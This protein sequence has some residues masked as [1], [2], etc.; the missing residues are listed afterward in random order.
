MKVI[1]LFLEPIMILFLLSAML[2]LQE[3][4]WRYLLLLA[5]SSDDSCFYGS[6]FGF[7]QF[8]LSGVI[9]VFQAL[10][11]YLDFG[12]SAKPTTLQSSTS[13]IQ[14]SS[15]L[16]RRSS[17]LAGAIVVTSIGVLV[18]LKRSKWCVL[19]FKRGRSNSH[20]AWI[21]ELFR[22]LNN[23][24]RQRKYWRYW[25]RRASLILI[26]MFGISIYPNEM[27]QSYQLRW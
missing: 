6:S 4:R 16:S 20:S 5:F 21:P 3:W 9:F 15:V 7:N 10:K 25:N 24:L 27:S 22:L 2:D 14:K 12:N 23:S 11:L 17:I 18:Y 19:R 1:E 26:F 13:T 8:T